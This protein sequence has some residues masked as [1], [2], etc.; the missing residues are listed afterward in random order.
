DVRTA[1]ERNNSEPSG[2]LVGPSSS[3][4]PIGKPVADAIFPTVSADPWIRPTSMSEMAGCDTPTRSAK[5][6]WV[7]P[8]NSRACFTRSPLIIGH[9]LLVLYETRVEPFV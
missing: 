1:R 6:V 2:K 3:K 9:A 4:N 7:N 8:N 5:S